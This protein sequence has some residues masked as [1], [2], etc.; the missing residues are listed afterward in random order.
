MI[1]FNKIEYS[2]DGK[3][4]ILDIEVADT[5]QDYAANAKIDSVV[6]RNPNEYQY[7]DNT[8]VIQSGSA[9]YSYAVT[10]LDTQHY[11]AEI[12]LTDIA[13]CGSN[14]DILIV[15]AY[16]SGY[17]PDAPCG[18]DNTYYIA[19]AWNLQKV[20]DRVLGV[21]R[22]LCK[23][24][25]GCGIPCDFIDYILKVQAIE[26]ALKN[27]NVEDALYY[28]ESFF[29]LNNTKSLS[30]SGGCGCHG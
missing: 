4:L 12:P 7:K 29:A 14:G 25:C 30:P 19:V 1:T 28:Y 11:T 27:Q 24:I 22:D 18:T 10:D 15:Q 5:D 26:T 2:E 23:N 16:T 13:Y 6:I 9:Y 20:Y 17:T 8:L 21:A 3:S